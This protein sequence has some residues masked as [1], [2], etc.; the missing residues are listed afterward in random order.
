MCSKEETREVIRT[1]NPLWTKV[2]V[3]L[4]LAFISVISGTNLSVSNTAE[5]KSNEA[6]LA[7][8]KQLSALSTQVALFN[9]EIKGG[10]KLL[11][12]QIRTVDEK[13][14]EKCEQLNKRIEKV[15]NKINSIHKNVGP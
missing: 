4:F 9:S 8:E 7:Q 10:F 13:S 12:F 2:F 15:E 1:E 5:R 14:Q 6:N 11:Q 3:G